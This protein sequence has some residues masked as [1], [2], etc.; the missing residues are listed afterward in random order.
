MPN[1]GNNAESAA[2][3]NIEH[4]SD[5]GNASNNLTPNWT[6]L[7]SDIPD[8]INTKLGNQ[9][10]GQVCDQS[11]VQK[12][13]QH[14]KGFIYQ[15]EQNPQQQYYELQNNSPMPSSDE[16]DFDHISL[17]VEV[18]AHNAAIRDELWQTLPVELRDCL[19]TELVSEDIRNCFEDIDF[20]RKGVLSRDE[21]Y[22]AICEAARHIYSHFSITQSA[23]ENKK[24][25]RLPA[26]PSERPLRL[27]EG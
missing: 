15:F 5:S 14:N 6:A 12:K 21:L 3:Q 11:Q 25:A 1:S 9:L 20:D 17:F 13:Q 4:S 24:P 18:A 16:S 19:D 7:N 22:P 27:G 23:A 2:F 10:R 8:S 26:A